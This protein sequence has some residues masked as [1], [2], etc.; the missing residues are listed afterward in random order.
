MS[1]YHI[2]ASTKNM[3]RKEWLEMRRSGIGGSDVPILAGIH[4]YKSVLQLWKEKRGESRLEESASESAYWGTILEDTVRKEFMKRTGL[5]VRRKNFLL[6]HRRY[7]FMIADV[8]GIIREPDG[9]YAVFEAKTAVE[10]K[11]KDWEEG[12]IPLSYQLQIQHY[13]AVTGF[14]K[15]YIAALVG[16]NKFYSYE[17]SRD[18]ACIEELVKMEQRFWSHVADG[19][20][21]EIDGSKATGEYLDQNYPV[22]EKETILELD[23]EY[24][25][26]L[27]RYDLI[28]V[29]MEEMGYEKKKIE[30]QIKAGLGG[31]ENARAGGYVIKWKSSVQNRVDTKKLKEEYQDVYQNCIRPIAVRRFSVA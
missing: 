21:P 10:Y 22:T 4:P 26:L 12:K 9:S 2:L 28:K 14:E 30:N 6:Q 31:Y 8:D 29:Q 23:H 20:M 7:P 5:K 25:A 3:D 15:A 24:D 11:N 27:E 17:I 16:G 19:T 1:C 13:L 18:E